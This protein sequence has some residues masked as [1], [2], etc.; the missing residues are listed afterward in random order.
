MQLHVLQARHDG[1]WTRRAMGVRAWEAGSPERAAQ[2]QGRAMTQPPLRPSAEAGWGDQL[3]ALRTKKE[4][5]QPLRSGAFAN[6]P[7]GLSPQITSGEARP[8]AKLSYS[9]ARPAQELAGI[10]GPG[11]AE[12]IRLAGPAGGCSFATQPRPGCAM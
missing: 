6:N 3:I 8:R 4:R 7:R 12:P 10:G 9:P 5:P 11:A 2:H 1:E